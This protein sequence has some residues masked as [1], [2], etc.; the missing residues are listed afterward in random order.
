M[1]IFE[2]SYFYL[3]Y[4]FLLKWG[5]GEAGV[6]NFYNSFKAYFLMLSSYYDYFQL[7]MFNILF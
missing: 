1:F 3:F 4:L 5:E 7:L 2:Q 6:F